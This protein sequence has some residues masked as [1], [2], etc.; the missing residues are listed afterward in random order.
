MEAVLIGIFFLLIGLLI[1]FFIKSRISEEEYIIDDFI[2]SI[3]IL[4]KEYKFE[5]AINK[6]NEKINI[7]GNEN[8]I[9]YL[10]R[11]LLLY[12]KTKNYNQAVKIAEKIIEIDN[13]DENITQY[14]V[15]LKLAILYY[16]INKDEEA[17]KILIELNKT[18]QND[19]TVLVYLGLLAVGQKNFDATLH[20]L[21]KASKIEQKDFRL[22]FA[23]SVS[24][25]MK[26]EFKLAKDN[27]ETAIFLK[28]NSKDIVM[29]II[30]ALDLYFIKEYKKAE[31]I[32]LSLIENNI[33]DKKLKILIHRL[34]GNIYIFKSEE[35]LSYAGKD[36][37]D[38]AFNFVDE[39][40]PEYKEI[41]KDV[42]SYYIKNKLFKKTIK[43]FNTLIEKENNTSEREKIKSMIEKV[44]KLLNLQ[45]VERNR[46][47]F[48]LLEYCDQNHKN[49]FSKELIW[50]LSNL[51]RKKKFN[52]EDY[53]KDVEIDT[54][55]DY[56]ETGNYQLTEKIFEY[57]KETFIKTAKAVISKLGFEIQDENYISDEV[58]FTNGDGIDC[59]SNSKKNKAKKYIIQFRRWDTENIGEFVLKNLEDLV[60]VYNF[61]KGLFITTGRLSD[62]AVNFIEKSQLINVIQK[63]QLEHLL[64]GIIKAEEIKQ[65]KAK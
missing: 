18:Y 34:L 61:D 56:P 2:D 25:S 9:E 49:L 63:S 24:H 10:W 21:K 31:N 19:V 23:K 50:E 38:K 7:S 5:E 43:T 55:N 3:E 32:L 51:K 22:F 41:L 12:E 54:V 60:K 14:D 15:N 30:L 37:I 27:I 46:D 28:E 13:Y 44:N 42:L 52:L 59:I 57:E 64:Q 39:T 53:L 26:N 47:Y 62:E 48:N 8:N 1:F 58:Q 6:L 45:S 20:F 17:F 29:S 35:N 40:M 16:L 4:E 36:F 11:L 65:V 33:K